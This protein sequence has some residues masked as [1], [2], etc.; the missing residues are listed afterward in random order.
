[1]IQTLARNWWLLLLC[2]VLQAPVSVLYLVTRDQDGPFTLHAWGGTLLMLGRLMLA[3]GVCAVAA[4]IWRSATGKCWLLVSHGLALGALGILHFL[5]GYA[6][7]FLTVALLVVL[8]ALSFGM[9]A[10]R[11]A[12]SLGRRRRVAD[13]WF[14]GLAGAGS[15]GSA[16][17]FLALGFGGVPLDPGSPTQTL[18]WIGAYLGFSA[19]CTLWLAL[20]LHGTGLSPSAPREALPP[21][22]HPGH[23]R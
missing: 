20:R 10:W 5:K 13:R 17:A 12:R 18:H 3:A 14:L 8:M 7:S 4:G 9:L 19:I 22:G 6:I 23:A 21:S 15:V 2:G 16:L 1:M 11:T